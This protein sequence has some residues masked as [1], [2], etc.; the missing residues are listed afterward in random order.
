MAPILAAG[1]RALVLLQSPA[2]DDLPLVTRMRGALGGAPV[3]LLAVGARTPSLATQASVFASFE[4]RAIGADYDAAAKRYLD[5]FAA[6]GIARFDG[7]LVVLVRRGPSQADPPGQPPR[8]YTVG[9]QVAHAEYDGAALDRYLQGL[10]LLS[11]PPDDFA[12]ACLQVSPSAMVLAPSPDAPSVPGEP[13]MIRIGAP[14]VGA[15]W[16]VD[17]GRLTLL[18]AVDDAASIADALRALSASP[19]TRESILAT[20]REAL[21]HGVLEIAS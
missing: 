2:R 14:G 13:Q 3:D 6:R 5:H 19:S 7:A 10:D 18:K 21:V 4:D 17:T 20:V 15:D 1:G 9:I 8:R 12:R 16:R 11:L